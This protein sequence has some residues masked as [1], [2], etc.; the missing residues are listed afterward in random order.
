MSS[1]YVLTIHRSG[2][3]SSSTTDEPT[4]WCLTSS[5]A[6][7]LSSVCLPTTWWVPARSPAP[8]KTA[9]SFR[10][11]VKHQQIALCDFNPW[12]NI[13][14]KPSPPSGLA[15]KPPTHKDHD[16]SQAPKFTHPLVN[17]SVIAGYNAT[18]SCSVRGIPKVSLQ[19]LIIAPLVAIY[20]L[21]PWNLL[22]V[23]VEQFKTVLN[24]VRDTTLYAFPETY[25]GQSRR[26]CLYGPMLL[27]I[28][29][30]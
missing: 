5:W 26:V 22:K 13:D 30:R 24:V 16:F 18:L 7:S 23:H 2:L 9:L 15:Y 12:K 20:I 8:P 25:D 29:T 27:C 21:T 14:C 10:K 1:T 3:Q 28:S 4:V 6:M 19:W 17:R 11:Q